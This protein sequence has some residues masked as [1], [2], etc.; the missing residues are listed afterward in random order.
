MI[1]TLLCVRVFFL[2]YKNYGSS[3][4]YVLSDAVG[5]WR[6][7]TL[8]VCAYVRDSTYLISVLIVSYK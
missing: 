5:G 8:L 7:L 2:P 3:Y 6:V 1:L 4:M